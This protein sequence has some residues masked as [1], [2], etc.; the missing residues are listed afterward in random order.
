MGISLE[1]L[2]IFKSNY[3]HFIS[4]VCY[5]IVQKDNTNIREIEIQNNLYGTSFGRVHRRWDHH[6]ILP[7]FS[8]HQVSVRNCRR[9]INDAEDDGKPRVGSRAYVC[10]SVD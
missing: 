6:S 4:T 8:M 3:F 2:C 7:G 10:E 5:L 1:W 9:T